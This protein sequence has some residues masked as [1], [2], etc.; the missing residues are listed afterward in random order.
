[1]ADFS[2]AW[3][4]NSE[5]FDLIEL[6]QAPAR[7]ASSLQETEHRPW[8]LPED[9][10]VMGQSWLDL[11]FAHWRIDANV[12]REHVPDGLEVQ[13]HDGSAWLGVT[14]FELTGLRAR[15]MLP[16]PYVSSFREINVRTYVTRDEKP[17]IW[18]LSLD[19]SSQI[20]VELARRTYKLP[21]FQ[22]RISLE[23]RAG[24]IFYESVR[25]E[26]TAFSGSYR[27]VGDPQAP[28]AGS[29]E[30]FLTERYCLYA[31]D[32]GRL[33]RAEIHHTPWP[34][35]RAEANI[36]LNTMAPNGL[37]MGAEPVLHFSGRQDVVIW[38]LRPA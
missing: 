16:L 23:R 6:L 38:P 10:W 33:H 8:P 21:Y 35:Q 18:F 3:A 13:E 5:I 17:G 20:A 2:L 11:L 29:L 28:R 32:R 9:S 7:Q 30:H 34:L 19:A 24:R 12:L 15:G 25:D 14:P 22:A 36:D 31:E 26:R 27:G 4:H 37:V 1:V